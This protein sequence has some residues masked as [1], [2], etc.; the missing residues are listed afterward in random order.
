M[1]K[2]ARYNITVLSKDINSLIEQYSYC[3]CGQ[4][5]YY[6]YKSVFVSRIKWKYWTKQNRHITVNKNKTCIPENC[7]KTKHLQHV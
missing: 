3:I 5:F 1:P 6:S 2:W 7:V 4:Y